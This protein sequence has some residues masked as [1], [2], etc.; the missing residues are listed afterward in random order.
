MGESA[1]MANLRGGVNLLSPHADF[2]QRGVSAKMVNLR[3]GS[4]FQHTKMR[5]FRA[6]IW[7]KSSKFPP[8][9]RLFLGFLTLIRL[10]WAD[11]CRKNK[12]ILMDLG[13]LDCVR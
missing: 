6:I 12:D 9:A 8:A 4:K 10:V 7:K 11:P 1:K 13:T 3:G 2:Y 5:H